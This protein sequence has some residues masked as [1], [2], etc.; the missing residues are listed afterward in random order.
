MDKSQQE[1]ESTMRYSGCNQTGIGRILIYNIFFQF[2]CT[3]DNRDFKVNN[4]RIT[5]SKYLIKLL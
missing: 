3:F 2:L 5:I 4:F 1:F